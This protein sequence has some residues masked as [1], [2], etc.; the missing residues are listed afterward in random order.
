MDEVKYWV[1]AKALIKD[2]Q[3]RMLLVKEGDNAGFELPGGH[4]EFGETGVQTLRRE[5]KEELNVEP[6]HIFDLPSFIWFIN[7]ETIWL[8]YE[9][10]VVK[11]AAIKHEEHS[12]AGYFDVEELLTQEKL[13]Y[14]CSLHIEDLQKFLT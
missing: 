8:V 4:I 2:K 10:V 6:Q 1:S 13:G 3:G 9:V 14:C 11:D 7:G 5:L 12:E